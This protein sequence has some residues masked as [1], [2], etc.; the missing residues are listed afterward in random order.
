MS[1]LII[2]GQGSLLGTSR[3]VSAAAQSLRASRHPAP[4]E[5]QSRASANG[6]EG[7]TATTNMFDAG[8]SKKME[9]AS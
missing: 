2:A 3:V 6:M 4:Q 7:R 1:D 5:L 8:G 9:G